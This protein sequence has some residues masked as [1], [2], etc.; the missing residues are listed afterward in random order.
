MSAENGL[1]ILFARMADEERANELLAIIGDGVPDT[2]EK[3]G[4]AVE[5]Y[6]LGTGSTLED[7]VIGLR[8]SEDRKADGSPAAL[9]WQWL[10]EQHPELF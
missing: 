8:D 1:I 7:A 10:Q 9:A 2:V 3:A 5:L 6:A 4:A